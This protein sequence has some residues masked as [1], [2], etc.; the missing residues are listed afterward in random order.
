MKILLIQLIG[1]GGVQLYT[2][3]LANALSKTDNEVFV[4]LGTH[5][6]S[7]DQYSSR[8]PKVV[9]IDTQPS[10]TKMLIKM[11]NPLVYFNLIKI[12]NQISPDII[13]VIYEETFI[14]I[15]ALFLKDKYPIVFTEHDP[16]FHQGEFILSKLHHGCTKLILRNVADAVIVHGNK[17]KSILISKNVPEDK[18]YIVPH[19]EF[20]FYE[21]WKTKNVR[22]DKSVLFFGRIQ[23]YK[24]LDYLIKAEPLITSIVPDAKIVIAGSGD[25]KKYEDMIINKSSFDINNRFIPDEE[26]AAFFQN[27]SV[28]VLPYID[29]SQT[30]IIP[31]AYSFS[32]PVIVTDVGSIPE[33]V[34]DGIT[35]YVIPPN[36]P[37]ALA[38]AIV[39]LLKDDELRKTMG[40]NAF[41]KAKNELSW[42]NVAKMTIN[43]YENVRK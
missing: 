32:K 14:G 34:D 12:I 28:V 38:D 20:S 11:V 9:C 25:F 4:L 36:D 15:T 10:Y 33:V 2:S 18:I 5:N 19:G 16:N 39:R 1:R 21:K 17:M 7:K 6:F 31:I 30:G 41:K 24:G 13:H 29:G 40:Q 27:A 8:G 37:E 35:G 22:E 42:G 26:V 3:Q 43:I 23:D